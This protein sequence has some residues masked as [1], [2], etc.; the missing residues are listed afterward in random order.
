M[1]TTAT[2][3][4]DLRY[5]ILQVAVSQFG[6]S[7]SNLSDEERTQVEKIAAAQVAIQAKVLASQECAEVEV[8]RSAVQQEITNVISRFAS[9]SEFM[10]TLA[11]FDLDRE[12]FERAVLV[13]LRVDAT[14]EKVAADG[15]ACT[16]TDAKLYYYMNPDKFFRAEARK[17]SHILITLNPDFPENSREEASKR[18]ATVAARLQ[19]KPKRFSEQALKY[20][21]CP[22]AMEGGN[23]GWIKRGVLFPSLENELFRMKAGAISDVVESPI[24]FHVLSCDVVQPEGPIPLAEVLPNIVEKLTE[25]NGKLRQRAWLKSL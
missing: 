16:E 21:E 2:S 4:A 13:N 23:L 1:T 17:A 20:S 25:R 22:T 14:M 5:A 12:A 11:R 15:E 24:G 19:K 6:D 8:P 3:K 10:S 9:E 7:L 18:A